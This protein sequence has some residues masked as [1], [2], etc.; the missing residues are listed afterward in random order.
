[1]A[2]VLVLVAR[3]SFEFRHTVF[4]F[5]RQG[6]WQGIAKSYSF[7]SF[8]VEQAIRAAEEWLV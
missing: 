8:A 4:A 6:G 5:A 3:G 2:C 1:M 7:L